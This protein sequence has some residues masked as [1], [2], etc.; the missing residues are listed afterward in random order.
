MTDLTVTFLG[1][2]HESFMTFDSINVISIGECPIKSEGQVAANL[3]AWISPNVIDVFKYKQGYQDLR[4]LYRICLK[5]TTYI[6]HVQNFTDFYE[7]AM[8]TDSKSQMI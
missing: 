7:F 5:N 3:M 1:P 2:D 4:L 6:T 8:V